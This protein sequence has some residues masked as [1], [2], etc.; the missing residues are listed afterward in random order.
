M[1]FLTIEY[2]MSNI[3]RY[4]FAEYNLFVTFVRYILSIMKGIIIFST[5]QKFLDKHKMQRNYNP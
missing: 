1:I 5:L 2:N 3:I 4:L